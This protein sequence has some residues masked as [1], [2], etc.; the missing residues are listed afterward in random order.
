MKNYQLPRFVFK[1]KYLSVFTL[2]SVLFFGLIFSTDILSQ[3]VFTH[4]TTA[5]FIQGYTDNVA[6]SGNQVYLNFRGTQINNWVSATDLPQTLTGHQ[7][8]R[9]RSYVYL[10]G[11]YNGTNYSDA[12]YRATMQT[13]G[14]STWTS[15]DPMPDSLCDHAMVAN[16]EFMYI[17]GG[18]KDNYI[19]DKI[20]FCKINSDGTLGEWTESAVTLPQPL[21]GHTAVFLNGYIYVAGGTNSSDENTANSDV[22]FAKIVDIDGNLSNFTAIS[23]LPQSRNGHSMICYGN[24]LIVMGGYD[25]S[26]TKHNTVYYADL[27]LD[28]TCSAWSTATA[29]PA[30]VSNHGSTCRNGFISVIGGED[31]GGVSDKVYYANIDDFPSLTWVTSPDLLN[32]ARKDGAAYASDGQIMY[33]GG[34]NISGEPIVNTRYAALDMT[35]DKVLLGSYLSIPFYQLGEERDMVSLTYDLFSNPLNEYTIYYR[36]AGSDGQWEGWTD[37]GEDNPVVIGQHKQYLQYLIKYNGTGDP[38]I[39][40]H[41]IS[42]NI[43]GYTQLSG[44]LNGIDTLK[45][46]DSPFWATGNI[47]FTSGTHVIE[48][49][50]EILFSANTGLEIGQANI[51]FDGS[52]TDSIKLTSYTG[53][54]GIWNGVYFNAYSDNGVTSTLNYVIIEKAGNGDRNA[55][56]YSYNSNEPQINH[57]VFR[58]ADGYG[59]K[60]KNAGLSVSNCKMSDNT[61][62]GCYIEDSSPSFSGTDFLSNDYAGIYLFDLISNPNYYNCVI[63]GNYFGIFYPSPNFSFPVITG[64]TSY[65]NTISGIAV[66]GGEITS[67]QT[68]PFNTLKYAVVGDITIA[69]Q[70]DNPRLTIAPGNT[71]YFDTAVQIQVGKYIAANHHYGGE[72]FAEGKADSLIT[73]TSLNGLSGGWDG[74]YFHYDSDHAGSVSE[75]EYCTIENGKDYNIKC[76]GTLQPTIANCTVTNSTGM[77]IYVQDPNSVPHITSSTTTVYVD[78]GTQSIDKIWYNFGGGDYIILNDIIV[79]LQNSHVR[80]TIEPGVTIKADTSV[81]LQIGNYIAASHNYGGELYAAGTTDSIIH[82]TSLNGL[83]GGWD[84]LYF[85]YNSDAFGSTSLLKVK[86]LY[87]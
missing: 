1:G 29:L 76:E 14:N 60:M 70:N 56:L 24:R 50:V 72:L 61:E 87:Y 62:S 40:L 63:E 84:G 81:M 5:D 47:S 36:V 57:S 86:V 17:I 59:I 3:V 83:S 49:G 12:V 30:D 26:G 77:D 85:H 6:V 64:I 45:L 65:N 8:T 21:W 41:D 7:V 19:S 73:F 20:Y 11:G 68:W 53:D 39:V 33:S 34:V 22:C 75:L 44:T 58:Q 43:S 32:V 54:T 28:G 74:I 27:N 42:L 15:Y 69:K 31:A 2:V 16:N 18:R 79:A 78:G 46:I 82:F 9:W 13:T 4:T 38:N 55:N 10:S 80:L 37:S 67:D 52:V 35:Y 25:N 51:L 48:A 71:I 66:A 23:S